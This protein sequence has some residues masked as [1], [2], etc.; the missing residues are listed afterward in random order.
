MPTNRTR[1]R[2]AARQLPDAIEL[3][4]NG[5]ESEIES[6]QPNRWAL[7]EAIW[8]GTYNGVLDED[9]KRRALYVLSELRQDVT[10]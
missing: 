9:D 1:R 5:R 8:F 6:T 2:R 7:T 10:Y 4:L 3:L